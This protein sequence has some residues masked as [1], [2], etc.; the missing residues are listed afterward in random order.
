LGS[1]EELI[2][3]ACLEVIVKKIKIGSRSFFGKKLNFGFRNIKI[4]PNP[5]LYPDEF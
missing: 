2:G 4:V 1:E 3:L 5:K